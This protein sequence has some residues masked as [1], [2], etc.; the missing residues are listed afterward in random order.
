MSGACAGA[1]AGAGAAGLTV[2]IVFVPTRVSSFICISVSA[3]WIAVIPLMTS[4]CVPV[5]A[6][7]SPVRV[8]GV[9]PS[10]VLTLVAIF[11]LYIFT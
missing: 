11:A 9:V 7:T 5:V 1:G 3:C 4:L 6:T 8:M 10:Q 2:G